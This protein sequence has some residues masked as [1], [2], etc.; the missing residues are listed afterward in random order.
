MTRSFV[1]VWRQG[2][3]SGQAL[4]WASSVMEAKAKFY[5][6]KPGYGIVNV[7]LPAL[8]PAEGPTNG[9]LH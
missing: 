9:S 2:S 5:Q 8:V 3:T 7:L 1:I 4:V 6:A